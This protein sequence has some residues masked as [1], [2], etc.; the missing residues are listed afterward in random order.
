M[1]IISKIQIFQLSNINSLDA[2]D[3]GFNILDKILKPAS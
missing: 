1:K 3:F 2:V